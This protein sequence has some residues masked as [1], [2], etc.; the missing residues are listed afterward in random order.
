MREYIT[1]GT[2]MG[3]ESIW[4]SCQTLLSFSYSTLLYVL[5]FVSA[6][7]AAIGISQLFRGNQRILRVFPSNF[8]VG[9]GWGLMCL[10]R[11]ANRYSV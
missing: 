10:S 11:R 6:Y 3:A 7:V 9:Y 4:L 5:F 2:F 1:M 8:F